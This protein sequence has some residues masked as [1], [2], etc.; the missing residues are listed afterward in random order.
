VPGEHSIV[1]PLLD[2]T[3]DLT[4]AGAQA[5]EPPSVRRLAPELVAREDWH[6][7]R[8]R[9]I[10]DLAAQLESEPDDQARRALI[11]RL[12]GVLDAARSHPHG[13]G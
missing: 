5:R 4:P 1:V 8:S 10:L 7:E 6:N 13:G 12:R 9:L 11:G 3:Y 2:D